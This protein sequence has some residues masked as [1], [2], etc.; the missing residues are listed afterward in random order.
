MTTYDVKH[1]FNPKWHQYGLWW[2][3]P[4]TVFI[5]IFE[6]HPHKL[7]EGQMPID[8]TTMVFVGEHDYD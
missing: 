8:K 7:L 1:I 3:L 2:L 5:H 4:S 6:M